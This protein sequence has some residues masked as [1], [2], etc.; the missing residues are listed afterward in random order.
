MDLQAQDRVHRIGRTK[1]VLIYRSFAAKTVEAKILEKATEK[2]RLEKFVTSKGKF[3]SLVLDNKHDTTICKLADILASADSEQVQV[4]AQGG[5]V[6]SDTSLES[7]NTTETNHFREMDPSKLHDL[8]NEV[9]TT[10]S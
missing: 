9:L 8:E 10:R 6:I 3:K 2:C 4:V 7:M 1:C 5:K